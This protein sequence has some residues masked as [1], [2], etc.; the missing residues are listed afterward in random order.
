M[1]NNREVCLFI[2]LRC[3]QNCRYCHRFL[4]IDEVGFEENK[5]IIDRLVEDGIKNLTFTGG[6]PL[7]YPNVLELVKYAKE[8]GMKNK[9]I[10]N[11]AIL[12]NEPNMREI[13]NYLDSLTLSID[14]ANNDINERI[15]RSYQHT[16]NIKIVLDSLKN[17]N[18]NVNI[19]TVVSRA[20][21]NELNELGGFLSK[22]KINVWRI[23]KFV[24]LRET[25]KCNEKEF[26]IS[27]EEFR[28]NRPLFLSYSNIRKVE[29]RESNDMESKY[30]LIMPNA[31]VIITEN[32]EDVIIGNILESSISD[33]L[34][35]RES[36]IQPK[37]IRKVRTLIAYNDEAIRDELITAI[38]RLN[39]VELVGAAINGKD[40]YNKI[41][42]LQ[43][44]MV[45]A[46][47]DMGDMNGLEIIERTKE[48]VD[49]K[50][51]I[52]N[53]ISDTI[54]EEK[55][56]QVR[57]IAGNKINVFMPEDNKEQ[58]ITKI[59]SDFREFIE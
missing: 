47:Y 32:K 1:I 27:N 53:F 7:L 22:Y 36:T 52:F 57:K 15:G 41:V 16:T 25:A 21:L 23:F 49:N 20:N 37:V 2:T 12:A 35:N 55:C 38:E 43:P 6:E 24:P 8:K 33:L 42:D 18:L 58:N 3:N 30:I 9:L 4:N 29:Y 45:F 14:C 19:N 40:T 17:I 10:T 44:E 26:E 54:T 34:R 11:G 13:Y 31:D 51:P 50:L 5:K 59:L 28:I 46:G 48:Q 56:N 39:Y